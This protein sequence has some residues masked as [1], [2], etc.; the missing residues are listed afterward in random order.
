MRTDNE[1]DI[2][3]DERYEGAILGFGLCKAGIEGLRFRLDRDV[4]D[5]LEDGLTEEIFGRI[6]NQLDL[7]VRAKAAV[8]KIEETLVCHEITRGAILVQ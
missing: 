3:A 4:R 7:L 1:T 5:A 6:L 8:P 2:L